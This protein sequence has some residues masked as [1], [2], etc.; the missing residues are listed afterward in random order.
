M[1]KLYIILTILA[2]EFLQNTMA[3]HGHHNLRRFTSSF[4]T[5]KLIPHF[6]DLFLF[7]GAAPCYTH[8]AAQVADHRQVAS[9]VVK[10][11]V[12]RVVKVE[13]SRVAKV[14][15]SR[16]DKV[17]LNRVD[18]VD[19]SRVDKLYLSRVDKVVSRRLAVRH[20][21]NSKT[22]TVNNRAPTKLV[23]RVADLSKGPAVKTASKVVVKPKV[24]RDRADSPA[25]TKVVCS[26]VASI[27]PVSKVVVVVPS[28]VPLTH[29]GARVAVRA[30]TC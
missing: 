20:P 18:K 28:R 22:L 19:L 17:D 15:L 29:L 1:A 21:S 3:M 8:K 9:R 11:E 13:V 10:V 23:S 16:V 26:K 2:G 25:E 7:Q 27:R 5:C 14:D 4:N 30:L 12:S 6:C 24:V